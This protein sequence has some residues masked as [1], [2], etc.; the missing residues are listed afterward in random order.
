MSVWGL[1]AIDG[2][3][4]WAGGSVSDVPACRLLLLERVIGLRSMSSR[5]L[6]LLFS[7]LKC[8]DAS[9]ESLIILHDGCRVIET[10]PMFERLRDC[11]AIGGG[12]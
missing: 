3:I 8:S 12:R 9:I 1:G 2:V 4:A 6:F 11:L 10:S 7:I 5:A